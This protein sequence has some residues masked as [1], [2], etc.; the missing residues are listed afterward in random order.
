VPKSDSDSDKIRCAPKYCHV[1]WVPWL[2]ITGSVLDDCISW[3][4][5]YSHSLITASY[6]SSQSMTVTDS[7]H[8]LLDY[9][10]LLF[11]VTLGSD[12]WISHFFCFRCPLVNTPLLNTEFLT[13]AEWLNT[14]ESSLMLRPTVS[15]PVCFGIKHT[16]VAYGQIFIIARLLRVC[17]CGAHT[18]TRGR[19]CHLQLLPVLVSTIILS[20]ESRETCYHILLS[21]IRVFLFV[22]SYDSQGYGGG[23][24]PRLSTE[25]SDKWTELC[26][27]EANR[28]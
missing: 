8:S 10:R 19:V 18:L 25:F 3:R 4:P 12:L 9:E 15:R 13:S 26:N 1:C 5:L 23:I 7:L 20:S 22:A 11:C 6:N 21:Q 24:R 2:I 17:W 27:F 28:I 14:D 16:S